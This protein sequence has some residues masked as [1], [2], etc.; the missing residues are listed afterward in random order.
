MTQAVPVWEDG[1]WAPL[2]ALAADVEADVCVVGL[3]G[4][5]LACVHEALDIGARVMGIDAGAVASGAAGRNGG[6]LLAGSY[7][8]YHDAVARY[9][10][11]RALG[12]YRAT[13]DEIERIAE[14]TPAAVRRVGSIRLATSAAEREDCAAQ[15]AA[16]R[17]DRLPVEPYEGAEGVGLLIPSDASFDPL[18]R[19]RTL[20]RRAL[21]RGAG[22]HENTP[23]L[24]LDN[25]VVTTPRGRIRSGVIIVAVDGALVRVLPELRGRVRTARLQMLATAPAPEVHIPRPVYAR[26]GMD[27]WQQLADGRVAAGGFRDVGGEAEWTARTDITRPVQD[28]LEIHLREVVGVTAPI[29]RR[30]AASVGY[31]EDGL[32]ILE[33]VRAGVWGVGAYS[34]TGNVIGALCGRA[35]ARIALLGDSALAR[36]FLARARA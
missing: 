16:M 35:A 6:F 13:L 18:L 32:P 11:E 33:E 22:L 2:P 1:E 20:A 36:P 34:G 26:Y 19:A 7:H 27:Y 29:T 23:A 21:E 12:I 24:S 8:F 30:W 3:G 5:G 9:G 25:G 10:R 14:E 17:A 4:S 15:L 28:A 31:T